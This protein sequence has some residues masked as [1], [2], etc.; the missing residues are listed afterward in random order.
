MERGLSA[1]HGG[2][3][4]IERILVALAAQR[5][6]AAEDESSGPKP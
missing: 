5:K 3:G 4:V 1:S 6:K 2:A